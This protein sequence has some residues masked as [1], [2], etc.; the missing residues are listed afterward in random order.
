MASLP[1][2]YCCIERNSFL[3]CLVNQ[4]GEYFCAVMC[5]WC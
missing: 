2:L 1:E 4:V 3:T 5:L